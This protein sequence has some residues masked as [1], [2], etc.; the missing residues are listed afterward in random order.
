[1]VT[2]IK[3]LMLW[4]A[5]T[6]AALFGWNAYSG[7]RF[8][9]AHQR[10]MELLGERQAPEGNVVIERDGTVRWEG[11]ELGKLPDTREPDDK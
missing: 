9:Q 1:M 7:Y 3:R 5:V 8:Q 10:A 2:K 11:I 4:V 6:L